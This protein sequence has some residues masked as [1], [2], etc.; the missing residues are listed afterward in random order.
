VGIA[1]SLSRWW[2]DVVSTS[3]VNESIII[4]P[5][6]NGPSFVSP[7]G[8]SL[9]IG[10]QVIGTFANGTKFAYELSADSSANVT[11]VTSGSSSFGDFGNGVSWE[12]NR[13]GSV[14]HLEIPSYGISGTVT[15]NS[16]CHIGAPA[17]K[18]AIY[19]TQAAPCNQSPSPCFD[20]NRLCRSRQPTTFAVFRSQMLLRSRSQA[21]G[22]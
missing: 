16:V 19:L 17:Q 13:L 7:P 1:N 2:W 11:I 10:T 15:V 22:G 8:Y 20:S 18:L 4:S 14:I 9:P 5:I 21:W 12:S 3:S 6:F